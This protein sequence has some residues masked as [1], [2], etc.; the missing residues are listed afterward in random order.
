MLRSIREV[1]SKK[2]WHI[3]IAGGLAALTA[4]AGII[5]SQH[6]GTA[7]AQSPTDPAA[8]FGFFRDGPRNAEAPSFRNGANAGTEIHAALDEP[9]RKVFGVAKPD[10]DFCLVVQQGWASRGCL[11]AKVLADGARL[12]WSLDYTGHDE[13][14]VT[15]LI[16][17]KVSGANA[18]WRS[19]TRVA[20][21]AKNNVLQATAS[22]S[23]LPV[24]LHW[25]DAAGIPHQQSLSG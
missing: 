10:G 11:P 19:G 7:K 23:E 12:M 24:T 5:L 15:A 14:Q 3:L 16:P 18:E 1:L 17:D 8:I 9:D 13:V 22:R 21:T 25:K 20:Y 4:T 2:G 6:G